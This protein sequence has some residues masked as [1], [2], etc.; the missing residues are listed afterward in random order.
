MQRMKNVW[1]VLWGSGLLWLAIMTN[2][3]NGKTGENKNNNN[4]IGSVSAMVVV[5]AYNKSF[6]SMPALFG[7]PWPSTPIYARLQLLPHRPY[8]CK[9][10]QDAFS[11][12]SSND[13]NDQDQDNDEY[14]DGDGDQDHGNRRQLQQQQQ[15][16]GTNNRGRRRWHNQ[17]QH[18]E[19]NSNTK[20]LRGT[21]HNNIDNTENSTIENPMHSDIHSNRDF[22]PLP[23]QQQYPL[24]E[25]QQQEQQ[26]QGRTATTTATMLNSSSTSSHNN[27]KW[28]DDDVNE[29]NLPLALLVQRGRCTFYEKAELASQYFPAVQYVVVY[30]NE[31]TDSLAAMNSEIPLPPPADQLG[32]TFVSYRS[33]MGK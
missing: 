4:F 21:N 23:R 25:Q 31:I 12:S 30:D 14:G 33:G 6:T 27:I 32:L 2:N 3:D 24:S 18:E 10:E 19:P 8:L 13:G 28:E 5:P 22:P 20:A 26:R 15:Q 9:E 29:R 11:S 7:A 17:P 16:L 1:I